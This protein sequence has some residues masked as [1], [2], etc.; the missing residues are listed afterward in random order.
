MRSKDVTDALT[1]LT[2]QFD[3]N[4]VPSMRERGAAPAARSGEPIVQGQDGAGGGATGAYPLTETSY[5]A[6]QWWPEKTVTTTDGL[7]AIRFKPIKQI[8]FLDANSQTMTFNYK[9]PD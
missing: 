7:F 9:G 6:R 1:A 2:S 3:A 8:T 5:A 4:V